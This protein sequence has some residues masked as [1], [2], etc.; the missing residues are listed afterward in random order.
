MCTLFETE[1]MLTIIPTL[2]DS[3]SSNCNFNDT[4]ASVTW[5]ILEAD[6]NDDEE[7]ELNE[8]NRYI[9]EK[10]ANRE[11]D[12]YQTQFPRLGRMACNYLAIQ[13][14]SVASERVFSA[15]EN[16]RSRLVPKTIRAAQFL[17][18][19]MQGPLKGKLVN[20]IS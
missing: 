6:F 8:I 9:F 14:S 10:M 20:N 13:E 16:M 2:N 18:S 12:A 3:F 19:W 4:I 1:Y 15:G 17:R 5:S 11:M 7:E